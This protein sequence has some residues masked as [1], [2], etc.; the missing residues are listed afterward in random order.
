MLLAVLV[1]LALCPTIPAQT[2]EAVPSRVLVDE[3]SAIRA[4][5]L[6][7]NEQVTIRAELTDGAGVLWESS[8]EFA[9]DAQGVMD[10]STQ[11]D[12]IWAAI[13]PSRPL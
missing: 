2:L 8:A 6:Q 7:P 9:A 12:R 11:T 3:S 4:R 10:V 1:C 13:L 5:G